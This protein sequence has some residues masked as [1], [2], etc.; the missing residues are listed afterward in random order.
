MLIIANLVSIGSPPPCLR[1]LANF[2]KSD[3][4]YGELLKLP[5]VSRLKYVTLKGMFVGTHRENESKVGPL[6]GRKF[7]SLCI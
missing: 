7:L 5:H 1:V 4:T 6:Q 2:C 3:L